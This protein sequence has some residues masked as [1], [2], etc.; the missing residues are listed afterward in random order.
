MAIVS[1]HEIYDIGF[2]LSIAMVST[3]SSQQGGSGFKPCGQLEC[4]CGEVLMG[5]NSCLSD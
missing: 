4:L 2:E 1:E 5:V 3:L